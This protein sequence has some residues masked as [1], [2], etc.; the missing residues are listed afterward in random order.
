ME[1]R[2]EGAD[3]VAL[4]KRLRT[5]PEVVSVVE[6]IWKGME[7]KHHRLALPGY[8][9]FHLSCYHYIS[10]QEE[11]VNHISDVLWRG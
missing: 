9:D 11:G 3:D 7:T 4:R 6:A 2:Y 5:L 10:M 8:M 1:G